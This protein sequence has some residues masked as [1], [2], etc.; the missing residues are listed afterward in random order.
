MIPANADYS[1]GAY[2]YLEVGTKLRWYKIAGTG[3]AITASTCPQ[4]G[5]SATYDSQISIYLDDGSCVGSNDQGSGCDDESKVTWCGMQGRD[6]YI[7]V[8]GYDDDQY[9]DFELAVS[10][11]GACVP[12]IP[13]ALYEN[14]TIDSVTAGSTATSSET[15]PDNAVGSCGPYGHLEDD[16][17]KVRWYKVVG[18]G[19]AITA[20]TCA[21][22]DGSATYDS[23]ISVFL[24]DGSCVG[25][26]DNASG[27]GLQS[28]VTWS[29]EASRD[30]YILVHGYNSN[31]IGEFELAVSE[32]RMCSVGY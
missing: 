22:D 17:K 23:K 30:Y 27:C 28:K 24:D 6:Y 31:R 15:I 13:P 26:N 9:G 14:V 2:T 11:A 3:G 5:G 4:D 20:S 29:S 18:T 7:M 1:C 12:V 8:Y 19:G 16:P 21:E 32:V 10:S 25:A